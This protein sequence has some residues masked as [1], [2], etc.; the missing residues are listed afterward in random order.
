MKA[1][2]EY[3]KKDAIVF[4]D[5]SGHLILQGETSSIVAIY[6]SIGIAIKEKVCT[7]DD[8]KKAFNHCMDILLSDEPEKKVHDEVINKLEDLIKELDKISKED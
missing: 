7:T 5:E 2:I 6:A 8:E 1:S 4:C 3:N